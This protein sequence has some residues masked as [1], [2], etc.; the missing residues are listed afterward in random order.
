[1]NSCQFGVEESVVAWAEQYCAMADLAVH[2]YRG[3]WGVPPCIEEWDRDPAL[4]VPFDEG[5]AAF[6]AKEQGIRTSL[7]E[8]VADLRMAAH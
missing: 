3:S 1:M 6:V 2:R 7:D 8:G 5:T 4:L